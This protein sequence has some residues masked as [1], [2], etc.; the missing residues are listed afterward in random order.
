MIQP[1]RDNCK[2]DIWTERERTTQQDTKAKSNDKWKAAVCLMK[3]LKLS[4]VTKDVKP[5]GTFQTLKNKNDNCYWNISIWGEPLAKWANNRSKSWQRLALIT[6]EWSASFSAQWTILG[7][8]TSD[9]AYFIIW[10]KSATVLRWYSEV[11]YLAANNT[12]SSKP[13]SYDYVKIRF[14]WRDTQTGRR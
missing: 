4:L 12:F 9:R 7:V 2:S 14:T 13:I 10:C 3:S 6:L 11:G 5:T 1:F 8:I